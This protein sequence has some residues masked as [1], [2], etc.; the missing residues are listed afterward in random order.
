MQMQVLLVDDH[1]LILQALQLVIQDLGSTVNVITANTAAQAREILAERHAGFD[2]LLLDLHLGEDDGFVLLKEFRNAYP[3]L[4]VVVISGSESTADMVRAIDG[5]AMGFVPK[6]ASNK[7]LL[8]ALGKVMSGGVYVPQMDVGLEISPDDE[9]SG[10]S[11]EQSPSQGGARTHI[12]SIAELGLTPRQYDTLMC[13]VQGKS[14]KAIARELGLS[15]ETVKS[16]IA[17]V[18]R[19]LNVSSRTQAVLV[20][21]QVVDL[22]TELHAWRAGRP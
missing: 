15:V 7:V 1:P 9:D 6:R 11:G 16:H 20:L 22:A 5:G 21:S 19:A 8:G 2:L 13:L 12:T 10:G 4:P 18:L 3:E 17:A 14:N